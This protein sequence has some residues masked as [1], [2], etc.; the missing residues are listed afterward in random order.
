MMKSPRL[1]MLTCLPV[2]GLALALT[3]PC[4][5]AHD[6]EPRGAEVPTSV[7]DAPKAMEVA[8]DYT[9]LYERLSGSIVK[10]EVDSGSGSGFVVDPRGLI[11][12]NYHVVQN[13]RFLA[14]QFSDSVL[15]RAE[16]VKLSARYDLAI[17]KVHHTFVER[18][19]P[20]KLL[21]PEKENIIKAGLPVVAFGSP[22]S[23]TFLATQGIVSKVEEVALLGDFLLEPGNS[24]GPLVNL[25]GEVIGVNTFGLQGIAGAVRVSYLRKLLDGLDADQLEAVEVS[26][27]PLKTLSLKRYPIEL[28]KAKVTSGHFD[29]K[30]YQYTTGALNSGK[31]QVTVLTPVSLA[32]FAVRD[33]MQQAENRYRRR[34]RKIHDPSYRAMDELF[35]E[36]HRN[37]EASL[38]LGV[39]FRIQPQVG[40][41]TGSL[42]GSAIWAGLGVY[43]TQ[44]NFEFKGE[45]YDFKVFRDGQ[46]IDPVRPGRQIMEN[47]LDGPLAKFVDEA[48][49][50][51]YVYAPEE[52]MTGDEF[53]FVI[54]NARESSQ[55]HHSKTVK[56]T[57]KLIHQIRSDFREVLGE[58]A[59]YWEEDGS[60]SEPP[61][62]G[63]FLVTG[64]WDEGWT[65]VGSDVFR[66]MTNIEAGVVAQKGRDGVDLISVY[67]GSPAYESG[68]RTGDTVLSIDGRVSYPRDNITRT[69]TV[70][71]MAHVLKRIRRGKIQESEWKVRH[72]D[73]ERTLRVT[74]ADRSQ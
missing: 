1:Q 66:T 29:I 43:N 41:T 65:R 55:A 30:D 15:A 6:S 72:R 5:L 48:Y 73:Q 39:T 45:F 4:V 47:T 7:A 10:V 9:A 53:R 36:W 64:A 14:V 70:K 33:E 27:H 3:S 60:G 68:L 37:V 63:V 38:D 22:L 2:S 58:G 57:S 56:A 67:P 12:T 49:A 34:G 35:Y 8:Y 20:L 52:F 23:Q 44:Q 69:L 16:I 40:L 32:R 62:T 61:G 26:D 25:E 11:A 17:L 13:T 24:G 21:S 71:Y 42:I 74:G 19:P 28:L 18:A 54:Y 50:G 46:L 31:F 59:N 51:V